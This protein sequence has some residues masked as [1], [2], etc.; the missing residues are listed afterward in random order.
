MELLATVDWLIVREGRRPD[1]SDIKAGLR[2]WPG[3]A[4]AGVRK[5][6]LFDDRMLLLAIDRLTA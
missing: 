5:L 1:L 6:R 2:E 4:D 3:G